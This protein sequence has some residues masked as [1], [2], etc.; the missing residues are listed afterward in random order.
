METKMTRW[1]NSLAVRVPKELARKA[2]LSD[3]Q[4]VKLIAKSRGIS[5]EPVREAKETLENLVDQITSDNS[6][7]EVNWGKPQGKER[8]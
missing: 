2:G 4:Y 7:T 1:G 5:I 3:N 8:W 6:H